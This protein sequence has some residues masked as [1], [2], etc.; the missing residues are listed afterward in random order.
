MQGYS[1]TVDYR[2]IAEIKKALKIPV[3]AS[4]DI[5]SAELAR[6]MFNETGCDA[7]TF[8][9]GALGNPWIFRQT[10]ELLKK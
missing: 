6:K 3:I 8:A 1:G 10:E 7:I 4:G 5:L 9:S 2:I